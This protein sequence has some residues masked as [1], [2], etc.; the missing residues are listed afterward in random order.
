V[1]RTKVILER[2]KLDAATVATNMPELVQFLESVHPARAGTVAHALLDLLTLR[3]V[4]VDAA[5]EMLLVGALRHL[6]HK[7]PRSKFLV[8]GTPANR[9]RW[10]YDMAKGVVAIHDD[11]P[12]PKLASADTRAVLAQSEDATNY[13][14]SVRFAIGQVLEHPKFG[15]GVVTGSVS[16]KVVVQFSDAERT[17]VQAT[18]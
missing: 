5:N 3:K 6:S 7:L 4:E 2:P 11:R 9:S 1:S 10:S 16:N 17:L 12:K 8:R 18:A 15:R 14:V 13:A